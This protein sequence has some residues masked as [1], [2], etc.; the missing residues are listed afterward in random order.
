[1]S[2]NW[3]D[4]V[5]R[6]RLIK[7]GRPLTTRPMGCPEAAVFKIPN[8]PESISAIRGRAWQSATD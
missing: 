2:I 7:S 4:P 6:T 5:E 3:D 1:M 8:A